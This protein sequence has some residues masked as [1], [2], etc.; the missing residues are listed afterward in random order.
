M[1]EAGVTDLQRSAVSKNLSSSAQF[2]PPRNIC[3]VRGEVAQK[4]VSRSVYG[5]FGSAAEVSRGV[6]MC[7]VLTASMTVMPTSVYR[8]RFRIVFIAFLVLISVHVYHNK[9]VTCEKIL[10]VTFHIGFSLNC[11]FG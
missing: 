2:S 4:V 5:H 3:V 1:K 9:S 7:N 10:L 8:A 6:C 11:R